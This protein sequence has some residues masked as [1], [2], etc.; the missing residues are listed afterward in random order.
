[1]V[2]LKPATW[3]RH[4]ACWLALMV[5]SLGGVA[6]AQNIT[7]ERQVKAAYLFKFAGFVEWPEASFAATDSLLQIG[8]AG[9]DLLADQVELMVAGRVVGGHPVSVRHIRPG[10]ALAGLH[11]LYIGASEK[12]AAARMLAE[13]QGRAVLTVSDADDALG[14]GCMIAF[15][16]AQDRLRCDVALKPVNSS[17][18][19]NSARMLAVANRVQGST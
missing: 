18:L 9:D 17:R 15:V 12:A 2:L 19:R 1:M 8:V 4:Y 7:L 16:V 3:L 6:S 5:L 11:I 13:I 10:E 14:L